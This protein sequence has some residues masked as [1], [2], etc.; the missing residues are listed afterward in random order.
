MK[1]N[2][3]SN[4]STK[5]K[6]IKKLSETLSVTTSKDSKRAAKLRITIKLGVSIRQVNRLL[7]GYRKEGKSYFIHGNRG[8]K[9][10][11][12]IKKDTIDKV[13]SLYEKKY[14]GFNHTHFNEKLA[15]NEGII[16]S[17]SFINRLLTRSEL[18]SKR[19]RKTTIKKMIKQK[20]LAMKNS[21]IIN[22]T[23]LG[24]LALLKKYSDSHPRIER[25]K[26][27]G[28]QIQMDASTE[29]WFGNKKT[30]LH[31][32]IDNA[33]KKVV[34]LWFEKQETLQGYHQITK[35]ILKKYG[36]PATIL[37]DKRTVFTYN[38]SKN[39]SLE[40]DSTTQYSFM[41]KNL[42]IN[43]ETTSIPQTKGQIERLFNT[44]QDRLSS[45]LKLAGIKTIEQANVFLKDYIGKINEKF[46]APSNDIKSVFDNQ[47]TDEQIDINLS[48]VSYRKIDK[49][50]AI[51]F[52]NNYYMPVDKNGNQLL[53]SPGTKVLVIKTFSNKLIINVDDNISLLKKIEENKRHSPNFDIVKKVKKT[54][55]KPPMTHPWKQQSFKRHLAKQKHLNT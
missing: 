16:L 33:S 36:I 39:K 1:Y 15:E 6:L 29:F 41:C 37:T 45:E 18:Y 10:A 54:L 32:A 19:T 9:P 14:Q 4:E 42:G 17:N 3:R 11:T 31:A 48:V 35:Q 5:Y 12:T 2:L 55:Y 21:S 20:M 27:F 46:A 26:Y 7:I 43:L 22:E 30:T 38:N 50:N 28:E 25:S 47:I 44:L 24:T 13:I 52:K 49:G 40:N 53:Y 51:K 34:G 8:K 23:D